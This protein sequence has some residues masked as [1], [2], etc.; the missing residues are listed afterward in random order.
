MPS[1]TAGG[2]RR[3]AFPLAVVGAN[4]IAAYLMEHLFGGFVRD[5]LRRHLGAETFRVFG[6]AYEPL[7]LGAGVLLVLWLLLFWLDRRKLFLKV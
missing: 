6:P 3:W 5:A 4:P 2:W 7:V 1:W